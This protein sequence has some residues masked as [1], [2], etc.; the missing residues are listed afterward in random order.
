MFGI[1]KSWT[2]PG[3]AASGGNIAPSVEAGNNQSVRTGSEVTLT[4]SAGYAD[5]EALSYQWEQIEGPAVS[6]SDATAQSVTFTAP[7]SEGPL[8]FRFTAT[9]AGGA[10]NSDTV[11]VVVETANLRGSAGSGGGGSFGFW[12]LCLLFLWRLVNFVP[13][14]NCS[15]IGI[16]KPKC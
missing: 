15:Q 13:W 16:A 6:L 10:S 14:K 4:G 7:S 9:D 2:D 12:A 5:S 11:T 3:C 1:W 8:T